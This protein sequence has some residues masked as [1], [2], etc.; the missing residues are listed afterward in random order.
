MK[1][2]IIL[3]TVLISL[4]AGVSAQ[5]LNMIKLQEMI[6]PD[7]SHAYYSPVTTVVVDLTVSRETIKT[8]PYARFAQKFFGVIAPLADKNVY[9]LISAS[10]SYCDTECFVI[11]VPTTLPE[12]TVVTM[13]HRGSAVE[14][15]RVLPDRL[16]ASGKSAEDAAS[17][18]AQTIFNL[19]KRRA[20]LVTGEYAETV[21]GAG[22]QAAIER[23]DQMENEYL[24]LF[25]GKQ[26][27][28]TYT[29]RYRVTPYS[30]QNTEVVCRFKED[31]GIVPSSDLSG[32]PVVLEC[33]PE[34]VA[35]ATYP[36]VEKPS[37]S[38]IP[39]LVADMVNCRVMFGKREL[40]GLELPMY[41]YGTVVMISNK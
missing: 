13:S 9:S 22:L 24:E 30:S 2:I 8:G 39:Y 15:P 32:E 11:P 3:T 16:S 10:L 27:T 14:F 17:D 5:S 28:T 37:K 31:S 19:R 6:K 4:V 33:R 23:I 38:G 40:G 29:V 12:Q 1:R 26:T 34:G 25:F 35:S 36:P 7:R 20:D 21:Y 18:A 41:Q